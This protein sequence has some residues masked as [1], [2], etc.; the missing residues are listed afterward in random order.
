MTGW[1]K[2][3]REL[4]QWE[5]FEKAEM[6]QLFIYLLLKVNCEDKQ[7]QGIVIKRGQ[8]VTSNSTIRRELKLSEQ[9][10]R[11]CIKRLISTGEITCQSTNRYIII[12]ICNYDKYQENKMYINEQN[13]EQ[14]NT[15][16]TLKQQ[17]NNEQTTTTKEYNNIKEKNISKD[18]LKKKSRITALSLSFEQ[19]KDIFIEQV[20]PYT[21]T[22]GA[23][24]V[25]DFIAYW[26]E[27]NRSQTKMRYELERTWDVERRLSTW[28]KKEAQFGKPQ[29]KCATISIEAVVQEREEQTE[30][31]LKRY[32]EMRRNSVSYADAKNSEEY[33]RAMMEA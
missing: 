13:N 27:P 32:E 31:R 10:I 20:A 25:G 22:Y 17:T 12:T 30:E 24:M 15:Q 18:I 11:T 23:S 19:R 26:T 29:K 8:V 14:T 3:F 5:W 21:E 28:E 9:Q 4:L 1:I 6:V 7:W 2:I 16:A 33:R